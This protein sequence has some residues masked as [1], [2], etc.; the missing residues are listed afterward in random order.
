[1]LTSP[2]ANQESLSLVTCGGEWSQARK[3]YLSRVLVRA[4]LK[5]D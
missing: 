2:V 1:M 5:V 3:T 4:V